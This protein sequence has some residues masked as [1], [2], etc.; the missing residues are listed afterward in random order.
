[1]GMSDDELPIRNRVIISV[2]KEGGA[3]LDTNE[4]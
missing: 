2:S 3:L 4:S 1:M